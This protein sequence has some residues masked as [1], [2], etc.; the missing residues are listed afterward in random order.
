VYGGPRSKAQRSKVR[1]GTG[2]IGSRRSRRDFLIRGM[3]TKGDWGLGRAQGSSSD[4][5]MRRGSSSSFA[6]KGT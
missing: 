4:T 3:M 1:G 2:V 6:Y 5:T